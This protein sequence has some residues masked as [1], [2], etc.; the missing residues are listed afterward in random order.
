M[1][2]LQVLHL[3]QH[4]GVGDRRIREPMH[5]DDRDS[6]GRTDLMKLDLYSRRIDELRIGQTHTR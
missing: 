6:I 4:L 1:R 2:L 5:Q 3:L